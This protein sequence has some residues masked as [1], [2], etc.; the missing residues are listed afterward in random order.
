MPGCPF[1]I[2]TFGG[3]SSLFSPGTGRSVG[4]GVTDAGVDDGDADE[5]TIFCVPIRCTLIKP[6]GPLICVDGGRLIIFGFG[7]SFG[8]L[9]YGKDNRLVAIGALRR[10][11]DWFSAFARCNGTLILD[12]F[13][14]LG[15]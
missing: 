13:I 3:L 5:S 12:I 8:S 4:F 2:T 7:S 15:C 14:V 6:F 1:V 10:I 9:A 11:I